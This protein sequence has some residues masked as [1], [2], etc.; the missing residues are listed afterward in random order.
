MKHRIEK[1]FYFIIAVS[2]IAVEAGTY[3]LIA[4]A[5]LQKSLKDGNG[6]AAADAEASTA[7][8]GTGNHSLA[9]TAPT[10]LSDNPLSYCFSLEEQY[11]Q[12]ACPL[13]AFLQNGWQIGS[14]ET[15][16]AE[17]ST[18][19]TGSTGRETEELA[20]LQSEDLRLVLGKKQV[21]VVVMNY[22]GTAQQLQDCYVVRICMENMEDTVSDAL[23]VTDGAVE[24]VFKDTGCD[25]ALSGNINMGDGF[26]TAL[27]MVTESGAIFDYSSETNNPYDD[28]A[29]DSYYTSGSIHI[30]DESS[31][32]Y[33]LIDIER[34]QVEKI[35]LCYKPDKLF[36]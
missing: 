16:D 25:A 19:V 6:S 20:S 36:D 35:T 5:P 32:S 8:I 3:L 2:L 1:F 17:T 33:I 30:T 31:K 11:Y 14:K 18:A 21:D 10:Q 23:T 4:G 7:F 28:A 27:Q 24:D 12:L 22:S 34:D 26:D 29:L 15:D 13:Y 9:Y